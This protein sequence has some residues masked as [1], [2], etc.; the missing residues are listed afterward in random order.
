M[1]GGAF[2]DGAL[3]GSGAGRAASSAWCALTG[4][5][6]L[7]TART[8]DEA[9]MRGS[10]LLASVG[11]GESVLLS[12]H[13]KTDLLPRLQEVSLLVSDL[14]ASQ[15]I[16]L[17]LFKDLL[18]LILVDLLDT[19]NGFLPVCS[20]QTLHLTFDQQFLVL[21]HLSFLHLDVPLLHL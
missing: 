11:L 2:G 10:L 3:L 21:R 16:G 13:L 9:P 7:H 14:F 20:L 17:N 5:A 8:V 12:F 18:S 4:A 6:M 19:L 15:V 1:A